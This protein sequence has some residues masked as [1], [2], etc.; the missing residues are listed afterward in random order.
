[1]NARRRLVAS[2]VLA[3]AVVLAQPLAG[4]E[5]SIRYLWKT[6]ETLTYRS[7][8]QTVVNMS[9]VPGLGEMNLSTT[10]VQI[11]KMVAENVTADGTATVRATIESMKME[12]TTPM[13]NMVFDS[14]APAQ[15]ASDPMSAAIAPAMKVIV[16]ASFTTVMKPT[17]AITNV[18]GLSALAEKL[19]KAMP[20]GADLSGSGLDTLMSDDTMKSALAQGFTTLPDRPVRT[21]ETWKSD[22]TIATPM[23]TI[24]SAWTYTLKGLDATG[25]GQSARIGVTGVL[26][27]K[28]GTGSGSPMPMTI[29]PGDGSA[30]G[31]IV[32]DVR[33]GRMTKSTIESTQPMTMS[34]QGPDGAAM[35]MSA[36]TKSTTT[37]ELVQ[38]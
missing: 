7:T 9:G 6:G 22:F 29:T 3:F 27:G 1:M 2:T 8:Q 30:Q 17:G 19:Q 20:G 25:G 37:Y 21:G 33:S 31:E 23:M 28:A 12:M 13:G 4:Q 26:K 38:K 35:N 15:N 10:I 36:T 14:A 18:S 5:V 32:M 24:M 11:M 34:M 16:G